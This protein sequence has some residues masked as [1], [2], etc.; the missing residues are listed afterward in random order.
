MLKTRLLRDRKAFAA[1][2]TADLATLKN[3]LKVSGLTQE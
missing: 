2:M 3:T 1:K